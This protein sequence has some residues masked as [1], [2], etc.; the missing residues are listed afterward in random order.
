MAAIR[1]DMQFEVFILDIYVLNC[2]QLRS[3]TLLAIKRFRVIYGTLEQFV[4]AFITF[5]MFVCCLYTSVNHQFS[6]VQMP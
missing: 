1:L 2:P 4:F 6:E 3:M 5:T